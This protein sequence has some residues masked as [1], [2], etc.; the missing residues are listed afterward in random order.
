MRKTEKCEI[1][2]CNQ[3]KLLP[4]SFTYGMSYNY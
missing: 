3:T 4:A 1:N 2:L